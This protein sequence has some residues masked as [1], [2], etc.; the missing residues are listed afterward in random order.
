MDIRY[1]IEKTKAIAAHHQKEAYKN[2]RLGKHPQALHK[3]KQHQEIADAL[4][5][6]IDVARAYS[7]E[8]KEEF[9]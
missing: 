3:C 9:V 4:Y 7:V 2:E 8:H 6:L 5:T 1:A